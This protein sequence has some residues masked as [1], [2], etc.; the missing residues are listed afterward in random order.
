MANIL[1][2][3]VR[4]EGNHVRITANL[5]KAEDGFQLWSQTYDREINDIFAVQDEI[6][7]AATEALQLKLLGVSGQPVAS[8]LRSANPE[9]YQAYL[10]SKYFSARGQDKRDL[11]TGLSYA[12]QAIKL[13]A[14]YAT[15]WALRSQVLETMAGVNL[16]E[17]TEGFRRARE[18][19]KKAIALDP[20]LAAGYMAMGMVQ[21]NHDWDWE[22]AEASFRKAG[23]LEPG[24]ADLLGHRAYLTRTLGR[25]DEAIE[26]YKQAIAR[27][28]LRANFHL[29]LGYELYFVGRYEEARAA[30][31]KAQ[32]LNPQLSSLH[33]TRGKILFSEGRQQEALA[34]MERET[35]EWEKLSGEAL[36]YHALGRREESD[37]ALKKL[38]ASHQND[39]AY[40]IAEAY[41]YRGETDKA[42]AWLERAYR[43]R[44]PGT[45]EL[46]TGP[47]MR[48]LRQDPRY[49]E[50]VKKMRLP[51]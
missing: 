20:N 40:Q 31:R 50:L 47:L 41:A 44:D 32:E 5:I 18:S 46:K 35:G 16:I 21:I 42:F 36:A 7:Q 9:A 13:D 17:N 26:L 33:L 15:A 37:K 6:A 10:Q 23:Q 39:S 45:P 22:G 4:R 25:V 8:N 2:G 14:N 1:E 3:S 29:A 19:A 28:P 30:L 12:D 11:D 34:E 51:T 27:D 24:S 43:Q 49:A 48:S 38:I